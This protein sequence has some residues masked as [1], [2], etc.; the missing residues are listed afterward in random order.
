MKNNV[1]RFRGYCHKD[2]EWRY[3]HYATD[4]KTHEI[5]TLLNN[6]E[7]YASQI[8]PESLGQFTNCKDS[9]GKWI[10][11]GDFLSDGHFL[12]RVLFRKDGWFTEFISKNG[13]QIDRL[14]DVL[15]A[16]ERAKCPAKV[17]GNVYDNPELM[18]P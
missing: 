3:G 18:E 14:A 10:Y 15:A 17:V 7:L 16:R 13:T 8:D 6:G 5:L 11:D 4:E 12:W 2:S 1:I 9:K